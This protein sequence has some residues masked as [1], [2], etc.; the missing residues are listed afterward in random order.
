MF[1]IF[2]EGERIDVRVTIGGVV[3]FYLR[4]LRSE[5]AVARNKDSLP[6]DPTPDCTH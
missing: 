5:L 4:N 6:V 2:P 1:H 3:E